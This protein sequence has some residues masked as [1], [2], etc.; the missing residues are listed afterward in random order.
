[1]LGTLGEDGTDDDGKK[2]MNWEINFSPSFINSSIDTGVW[3]ERRK[4]KK[5]TPESFSHKLAALLVET[6]LIL[7]LLVEKS[8]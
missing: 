1:M 6:T 4:S 2:L 3:N 7:L 8:F 5:S